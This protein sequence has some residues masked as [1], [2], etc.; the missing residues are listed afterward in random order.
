MPYCWKCG[1]KLEEEAKYCHVCGASVG[2]P[3]AGRPS[4]TPSSLR[5]RTWSPAI[6]LAV[7]LVGILIV[8]IIVSVF[9]FLPVQQVNLSRSEQVLGESGVRGVSLNMTADVSSFNVTFADL[10]GRVMTMNVTATGGVGAFAPSD[11]VNVTVNH[12]R[13]GH[14]IQV[15]ARI[16]RNGVWWPMLGGLNV[17]CDVQVERSL[18]V[19]LNI[20]TGVGRV[21]LLASSGVVL[22]SLNLETATG[23]AEASLGRNVF[24]KGNVT[25]LSTTGGA[26]LNWDNAKVGDDVSVTVKTTTGGVGVDIAEDSSMNHN[27][28]LNAET[29][30]GGVDFSMMIQDSVGAQVNSSTVVGGVNTNLTR[31]SGPTSSLRSENYPSA[32]NFAVTL[33]TTTGGISVDATYEPGQ[34]M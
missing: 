27:V 30:T 26:N 10:N 19:T 8:G 13:S 23:G 12:V 15:D 29:V 4:Q 31:F 6:M 25:I 7:V 18:N 20:K 33:K 17:V 28:T 22:D 21:V 9:V 32:S 1:S 34:H 14:T 3:S 5:R 24:V 16:E 11:P 2:Q